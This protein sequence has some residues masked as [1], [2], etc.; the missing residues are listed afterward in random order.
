[1]QH[2]PTPQF[3]LNRKYG[4]W[5]FSGHFL[6][7]SPC[8]ECVKRMATSQVQH[9]IRFSIKRFRVCFHRHRC[10]GDNSIFQPAQIGLLCRW[11]TCRILITKAAAVDPA[12]LVTMVVCV[13]ILCI[14]S[15]NLFPKYCANE[16]HCST[17]AGQ[18][19]SSGF[20]ETPRWDMMW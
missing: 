12:T 15:L 8:F 16:R 20:Y 1:M 9:V 14:S 7:P 11:T 6:E 13:R 19:R 2:R 4:F 10:P 17:G 18:G 5:T 3:H